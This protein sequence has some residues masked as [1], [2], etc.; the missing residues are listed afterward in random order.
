MNNHQINKIVRA[1]L[2][3]DIGTGDVTT[4]LTVPAQMRSEAV[5]ILREKAL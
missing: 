4:D 5:I 3:E 2:R 1:A